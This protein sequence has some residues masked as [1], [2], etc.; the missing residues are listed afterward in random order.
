MK[1]ESITQ[2][3]LAALVVALIVHAMILSKPA[4]TQRVYTNNQNNAQISNAI[5]EVANQMAKEQK[6]SIEEQM[7]PYRG[8]HYFYKSD[9]VN[10]LGI[11]MQDLEV[12]LEK[13]SFDIPYVKVNGLYIFYKE[14]VDQWLMDKRVEYKTR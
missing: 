12:L 8:E 6:K 9:L 10:Y 5:Y 14:A 1:K 11:P 7:E 4:E 13:E 3:L 2:L